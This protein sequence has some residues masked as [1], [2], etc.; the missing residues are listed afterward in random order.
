MQIKKSVERTLL[1]LLCTG[2][3]G[4]GCAFQHEK[5]TPT[6]DAN[7]FE[8]V[9]RAFNPFCYSQDER[10]YVRTAPDDAVFRAV[11]RLDI[12]SIPEDRRLIAYT[13]IL[14]ESRERTVADIALE[15][16]IA[17]HETTQ[18]RQ[19]LTDFWKSRINWMSKVN[20]EV[21]WTGKRLFDGVALLA[22]KDQEDYIECWGVIE[23]YFSTRP[24]GIT[25][26]QSRQLMIEL[27]AIFA[28]E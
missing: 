12:S 22:S 11:K 9:A 8:I 26:E 19:R 17:E 18:F 4:S 14:L 2:T 6:S 16:V 21:N 13:V 1:C 24:Q 3:M 15:T 28:A 27:E 5:R 10:D 23:A 25:S 7:V 20:R